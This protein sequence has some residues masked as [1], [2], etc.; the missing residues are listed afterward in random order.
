MS[1]SQTLKRIAMGLA[2]SAGLMAQSPPP[3]PMG[4]GAPAEDKETGA[5]PALPPGLGSPAEATVPPPAEEG[6]KAPLGLTGFWEARVG[7]R[8]VGDATQKTASVAETRLQLERDFY[9]PQAAFRIVGDFVYD[10]VENDFGPDLERGRGFVDLREANTVF[11]PAG[12]LDVK[13]GRQILTWGV[14]DL[15]FINDLFP[16]DFRAF[17]IGRDEEYLKAP[18]DAL[19]VSAFSDFANLDVVYTP[20]FDP[21]RY[22]DGS[23]LSYF[24]PSLGGLAGRNAVLNPDTPST[25]GSDDEI[26][27]RLYRNIAGIELAAYGYHGFWKAPEGARA[28]GTLFHPRL[29]VVG[30][31]LRGPLQGGIVTAEAGQYFSHDDPHGTSPLI[32]NGETRLLVGYER[33]VADELT[34]AAQYYVEIL[35]DYSALKQNLAPGQT[36]PDRAHHVLMLRLTQLLFNQNLTLSAF[37]FWSPNEEDGYTRFR[38]SYK[39][40]DTWRIEGGGNLFYGES[41]RTFF[42]QLQDNSNLFV[43]VRRSF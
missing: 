12:F 9:T 5:A 24:S 15:V 16:K 43:G 31:S 27:A 6:Y 28:D 36:V 8:I 30:A 34:A 3:L 10:A 22:V 1:G 20:R 38:A 18:S 39:L 17:F 40:S 42:G 11:Q 29:S 33:E 37:N 19:R 4:L 26:A 32:R 23:R 41:E 13:A 21:D 25:W 7:T 35:S 2:L 14:G